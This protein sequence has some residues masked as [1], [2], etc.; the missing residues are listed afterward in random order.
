MKT[1][2][3]R[4]RGRGEGSIYRLP[5]GRWRAMLSLPGGKRRSAVFDNRNECGDW[6]Y[7]QQRGPGKNQSPE[8]EPEIEQTL[9]DYLRAWF[10]VHQTS[11][12]ATTA[13]DY[14]RL[15]ERVIIPGLG[16]L[17]L[18]E[19]RRSTFDQ[20]YV[21]LVEGGMGKNH[22]HYTHRILHKA[23][24]DAVDDRLLP[25]NPSDRAKTPRL[26]H[27]KHQRSPLSLEQV[28]V[29]L[30]AV[31]GT[32]IS[33]LIHLAIKTGMR[34]GE[35]L[36]LQ[37]ED[38]DWKE[39]QI[40]VRRNLQRIR[41]NEKIL[42]QFSTPKSQ[43]G[44]RII[45]VGEG[46]LQVLREQRNLVQ[47]LRLFAGELWQEYNLVFPSQVG[48]PQHNSNLLKRYQAALKAAGL[49][50]IS[51]HA[52]RHIAASLMLNHGVPVLVVSYIL[53][54]SQPSTTMNMYGHEFTLQEVQAAEMMDQLLISTTDAP[55]PSPISIADFMPVNL[56]EKRV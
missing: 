35:L 12:K 14:Y 5:N 47:S 26:D 42:L 9:G 40:H 27:R 43:A 34:Q 24:A 45:N 38:I 46:T 22:V 49:P 48:T 54:H 23:L 8:P 33:P 29:L 1:K 53:G 16:T 39:R 28:H 2:S 52:L 32:L 44:D 51:F 4:Y 19:L 20:F 50:V 13:G 21:R 31:Q 18:S 7:D 17:K 55:K 41:E 37:W 6:L 36:A 11:L 25:Y 56:K 15:M 10:H 30:N 3:H